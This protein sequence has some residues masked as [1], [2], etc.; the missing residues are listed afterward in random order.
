MSLTCQGRL[1]I[2]HLATSLALGLKPTSAPSQDD[3]FY[4]FMQTY[5]EGYWNLILPKTQK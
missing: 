5:I 4:Q 2:R 3:P 1:A